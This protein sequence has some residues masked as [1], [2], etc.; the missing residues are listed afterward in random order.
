MI[1]QCSKAI[2]Q[3]NLFIGHSVAWLTL[4]MVLV[5]FLIVIL[6]YLFN[7]G[8][9]A[10][11]ESVLYMHAMV[12]MLGAA[13]TLKQNGHVRVDIF[14]QK[15]PKRF[16]ALVNCIGILL[17]LFPVCG[18]IAWSSWDYISEAWRLKESSREAGG[19]PWI[20]LLKTTIIIMTG[21]LFLQGIS[22]L[23]KNAFTLFYRTDFYQE[24]EQPE[25]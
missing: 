7:I 8:S 1:K 18:F 19:L 12:F 5:T 15:M 3:L 4:S 16:Q 21:L 9:I 24:P 2:D 10:I 25:I 14:Y 6:R 23:I 20:Y 17:L 13:F 11:Q 22:D